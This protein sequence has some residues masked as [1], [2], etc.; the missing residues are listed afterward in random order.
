M[1]ERICSI[2]SECIEVTSY[3]GCLV[4]H[5][6]IHVSL[7]CEG[8]SLFRIRIGNAVLK[9]EKGNELSPRNSEDRITKY[10]VALTNAC[11][12]NYYFESDECELI[13]GASFMID[14]ADQDYDEIERY[15]F[16]LKD[17]VWILLAIDKKKALSGIA[18]YV[19][20]S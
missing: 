2:T 12:I 13:D 18:R 6:K 4:I 8:N 3:K 20:I 9:T 14:L 19:P 17:G 10:P 1:K 15:T 16:T 7:S 5:N 11:D